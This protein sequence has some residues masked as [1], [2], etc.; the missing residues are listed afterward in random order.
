MKH[1][2]LFSVFVVIFIVVGKVCSYGI[3]VG[4][5]SDALLTLR[6]KAE[7]GISYF[8]T[9]DYENAITSLNEAINFADG[10]ISAIFNESSTY[11]VYS[12]EVLKFVPD[13]SELITSIRRYTT[14]AVKS[15]IVGRIDRVIEKVLAIQ[16]I[17]KIVLNKAIEIQSSSEKTK[18]GSDNKS[19]TA[20]PEKEV[21][22]QIKGL[23]EKL[24]FTRVR[25]IN[26]TNIVSKTNVI[27][28]EENVFST[29]Y[30][31]YVVGGFAVVFVVSLLIFL[32]YRFVK[33]R[34]KDLSDL[35]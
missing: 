26:V 7:R 17:L 21:L 9:G 30:L 25:I 18:V 3:G 5:I 10:I 1:R 28:H 22:T 8:I 33:K 12:E 2:I 19:Y 32:R 31:W 15:Y 23:G 29:K 35:L 27:V 34:M 16:N 14:E 6:E 13:K 20:N 24:Y 4:N 11:E